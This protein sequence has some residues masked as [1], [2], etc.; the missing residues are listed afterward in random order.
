MLPSAAIFVPL[1]FPGEQLFAS[2]E[3]R[4]THFEA[5]S[6][7]AL[8]T[9]D[10]AAYQR[11]FLREAIM[12]R[13]IKKLRRPDQLPTDHELNDAALQFVRKISGFHRPSQANQEAFDAAVQEVALAARRLFRS[14]RVRESRLPA[15]EPAVATSRRRAAKEHFGWEEA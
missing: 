1:R 13:N 2:V 15:V 8:P 11:G 7:P 9:R 14:L 6:N 10:L 3:N 12:C 5:F 4:R